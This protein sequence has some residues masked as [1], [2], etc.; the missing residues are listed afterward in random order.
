MVTGLVPHVGGPVSLGCPTVL[1]VGLP[2]ARVTDLCTCVGPPDMI[3]K[4]SAT[5]L[6][7]GLPAARIG[8][9]TVHGGV[10]VVGAPTVII[11]D[12]GAGGGGGVGGSGA[13]AKPPLA[14]VLTDY[15]TPDDTMQEWSPY[16]LGFG[17]R[18]L[19][20]A[21]AA[22]LDELGPLEML[23]FSNIAHEAFGAADAAFPKPDDWSGTELEWKNLGHND[24]FRHTYWNARLTQEFGA[25]WTERFTTAHEG[26]PGNEPVRE[27]QDLYNNE[28]G[29]QIA[30]QHPNASPDGIEAFVMRAVQNGD[31]IV[32]DQD[33]S[34]QWSDQVPVG[35]HHV[36]R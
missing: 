23:S 8:D 32:V 28:L 13:A 12:A 14:Q 27:A 1:T 30:Q 19:T 10:I 35:G 16:G 15:Q 3:A 17:T 11:G 6:V 2:Q 26:I 7:G 18:E 36:P 5:V 25:E 21:E 24:A 22:A 31:A 34:L 33:G 4:G 20:S 29:R 9:M